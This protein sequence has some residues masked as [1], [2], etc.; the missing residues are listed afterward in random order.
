MKTFKTAV[1]LFLACQS[2]RAFAQNGNQE[3]YLT[4]SFA[5][6]NI[7][8]VNVKTSGGS[9]AVTGVNAADAH[10]EVY[11]NLNNGNNK[12]ISKEELRQR[13]ED[14]E[15]NVSLNG[16]EL[17]VMAKP[18][19]N[20]NWRK[21]LSISFKVFV[22]KAVSSNLNTSG[23]SIKLTNLNGDQSFTTSGGSLALDQITGNIKGHTSG[24]AISVAN[25][26]NV[27]DLSTSGGSI[28]AE[29]CEGLIKLSTS[30]G[31]MH[32]TNLNGTINAET[33][34]GSIAGENI[35][36]EFITSTSG[37][38]INLKDM[39]CS[40][41]TSTSGGSIH[42]EM[43]QLGKY[44]K[45]HGSVNHVDLQLPSGRG[46]DLDLRG[47]R[48]NANISGSFNGEKDEDHMVGRLNGGGIPIT[49]RTSNGG[50]NVTM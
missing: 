37:G 9:I 10:V 25:T 36:G 27:I 6:A 43:K 48:I 46:L 19:S 29:N 24:G 17:E 42:V 31:A 44:V 23:G 35:K 11:V 49:V 13:L 32:F 33:S 1:I 47:S 14:Y 39:A 16:T 18:K 34:G 4:K 28:K 15:L 7:K 26:K 20:F 41:E 21:S 22:P 2:L 38:S 3:P 8:H 45:I 40:L 30:G 50:I 5:N 12:D